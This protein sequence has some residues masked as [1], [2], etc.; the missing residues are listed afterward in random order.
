MVN[1]NWIKESL[2][3]YLILINVISFL[4]FLIDKRRAKKGHYRISESFLFTISL[5]GG[6]LGSLLGMKVF[7]HKTKKNKFRFGIP[8]IFILNIGLIYFIIK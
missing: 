6:G 1:Q 5:M 3:I 4:C 2:W 7:H 8:L